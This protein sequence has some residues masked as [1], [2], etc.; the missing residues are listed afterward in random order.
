[1]LRQEEILDSFGR[2]VRGVR[3]RCS[4]IRCCFFLFLSLKVPKV[5]RM[6]PHCA[7]VLHV[8]SIT[9]TLFIAADKFLGVCFV[10]S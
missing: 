7:S 6:Y 5:R 4:D 10:E 3:E 2:G 8:T 9:G 1:M